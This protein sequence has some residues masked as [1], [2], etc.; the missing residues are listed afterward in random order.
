LNKIF[1]ISELNHTL[2]GLIASNLG[3]IKVDGEISNFVRPASGHYYFSLKDSKAQ[4]RCVMFKSTN[5]YLDVAPKNG[6]KVL[7]RAMPSLY[8]A[9]GDLQ[10]VVEH[11]ETAGLGALLLKLEKLKQKIRLKGWTNTQNKQ[12][13]PTYPQNIAVVTSKTGAALQD[14]LTVLVRRAVHVNVTIYPCLVQGSEAPQSIISALQSVNNNTECDICLLVRGGGSIEDLWSFNDERVLE[15]IYQSK[16]PIV[17]G[18]GH[19]TDNTL[20][21]L[22][23]DHIAPTPSVAAE[24]ATQSYPDVIQRITNLS[25]RLVKQTKLLVQLKKASHKESLLALNAY[26]PEKQIRAYQQKCDYLSASLQQQ[27]QIKST[28]AGERFIQ[29][30]LRLS[31]CSPLSQ[32]KQTQNSIQKSQITFDFLLQNI[33]KNSQQKHVNLQ[34]KLYTLDPKATLQRGY[35]ITKN[36]KGSVINSI[37][38]LTEGSLVKTMFYDGVITSNIIKIE[39]ENNK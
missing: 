26:H 18:V 19:E 8:E 5:R 7:V 15:A 34:T 22:V 29:L 37:N 21:E 28:K 39:S 3:V 33:I 14:V 1:S 2:Q 10:L 30:K 17:C 13:L 4:I 9:R 20:S 27:I 31:R 32:I 12:L 36:V 16:T 25:L 35:T 11:I 6:D 24:I 23:A 38:N